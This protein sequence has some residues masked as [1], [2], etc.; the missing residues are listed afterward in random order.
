M[1]RDQGL[2]RDPLEIGLLLKKRPREALDS[3]ASP[4]HQPLSDDERPRKA[5][6]SRQKRRAKAAEKQ[7]QVSSVPNNGQ[8]LSFSISFVMPPHLP[9]LSGIP[10]VWRTAL[11]RISPLPVM[12]Q[13]SITFRLLICLGL[14]PQRRHMNISITGFVS[15]HSANVRL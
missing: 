7:S 2:N 14:S 10:T 11:E 15:S 3:P 12:D 8:P 13:R 6:K 1:G 9:D 4:P 5:L